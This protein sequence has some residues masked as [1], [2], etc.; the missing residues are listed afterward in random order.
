MNTYHEITAGPGLELLLAILNRYWQK[1]VF[2][3]RHLSKN[4]FN[5]RIFHFKNYF[6]GLVINN[7]L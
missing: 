3:L 4:S 6:R 2:D 1:Q 7:I 5:K